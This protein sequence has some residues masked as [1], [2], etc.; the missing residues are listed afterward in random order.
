MSY[1]WNKKEAERESF[2]TV[3]ETCPEI[4]EAAGVFDEVVK[5]V[6][7][8]FRDALTKAIME[9][10]EAEADISDLKDKLSAAEDRNTDLE[11]RVQE[12]VDRVDE[13]ESE[14]W[15]ARCAR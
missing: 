7:G 15:H 2:K 12:L 8:R 13:L 6:T 11:A 4:D 3:A 10:L 9:R 14:A 1:R 5:G